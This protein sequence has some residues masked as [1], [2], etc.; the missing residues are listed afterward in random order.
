MK[1]LATQEETK[2]LTI[3]EWTIFVLKNITGQE[4][5]NIALRVLRIAVEW[6]YM[7]KQVSE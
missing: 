1:G 4:K 3:S 5:L 2:A 6:V 7:L